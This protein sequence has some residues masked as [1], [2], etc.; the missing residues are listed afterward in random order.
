[1]SEIGSLSK[2]KVFKICT[3]AKIFQRY[4][5]H[6]TWNYESRVVCCLLR[7]GRGQVPQHPGASQR[8]LQRGS[9]PRTVVISLPGYTRTPTALRTGT[10]LIF[11]NRLDLLCLLQIGI[12]LV[13]IHTRC[14]RTWPETGLH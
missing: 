6:Y 4:R 8:P 13:G 10:S 14:K 9:L 7:T 3:V 1:M 2:L 5:H 12:C 11:K